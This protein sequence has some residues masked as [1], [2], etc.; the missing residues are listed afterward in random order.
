MTASGCPRRRRSRRRRA[1]NDTGCWKLF[2]TERGGRRHCHDINFTCAA[3]RQGP[4]Q[5]K[6]NV[7]NARQSVRHKF[8]FVVTG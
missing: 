7:C 2:K 4:A 5:R 8:Y 3:Q 6:I 1:D